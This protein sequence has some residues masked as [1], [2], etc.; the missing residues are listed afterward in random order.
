V[1]LEAE[2]MSPV[3][4]P[5]E[6]QIRA[7]VLSLAMPKPTF[8]SLTDNSGNYVQVVGGRPW[9]MVEWRQVDPLIHRR[10]NSEAVRRPY[11]DGATIRSGAGEIILRADEWLLL[12][13]AADIFAAFHAGKSFPEFVR[14]RTINEKLGLPA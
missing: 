14:W 9:C 5:T 3:Q 6:E 1:I 13:Q 8:A 2:G 7:F 12:K 10:A 11:K 4:A